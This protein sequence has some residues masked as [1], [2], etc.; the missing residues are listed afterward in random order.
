M[1]GEW[2]PDEEIT[3]LHDPLRLTDEEWKQRYDGERQGRQLMAAGGLL[4][5]ADFLFSILEG[6]GDW[7]D[8]IRDRR[9][10][11]RRNR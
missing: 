6:I 11:R 5:L 9:D 2:E 1:N 8:D 3:G 10:E 7:I 4:L